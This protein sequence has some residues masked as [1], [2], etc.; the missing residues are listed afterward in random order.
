[1]PNLK[2]KLNG[3]NLKPKHVIKYL[4]ITID[5]HLTFKTHI[6]IM[7]SKLKRAN[8]LLGLSRHYL[9]NNLLKQIYYSQFHSHL[10]YGC[11]VW[12]QTPASIS[13]TTILQKKAVRLMS[14]SQRDAPSSPIFKDL[15]ILQLNDLITTNNIIFVHKTLNKMSPSHFDH[16]FDPHIPDHDHD[17]RNNPASEYS[18][19]SGSVSLVNIRIDS[20]KYKCAQD[21]N[22]MLKLLH[23][24][25]GHTQSLIDVSIPNLKRISKAHFIGAY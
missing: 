2:I 24:N 25:V 7:N 16:F 6:N 9:P 15:Q 21:W 4:G 14:F 22:E 3:V 17:T 23:S 19:P 1:M 10:A 20:L 18:I 13:Q 8:N 12:G 11:Q 5:E